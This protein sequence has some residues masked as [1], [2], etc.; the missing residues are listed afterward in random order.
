MP[1]KISHIIFIC[2]GSVCFVFFP[3]LLCK[4]ADQHSHSTICSAA[5][6]MNLEPKQAPFT[7]GTE[8]IFPSNQS[9]SG[10]THLVF[11]R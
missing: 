9:A 7:P 1:G 6:E 8:M 2:N 4:C 3:F 11:K 5:T 10:N